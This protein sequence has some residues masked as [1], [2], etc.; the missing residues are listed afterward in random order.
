MQVAEAAQKFPANVNVAVRRRPARPAVQTRPSVDPLQTFP[1]IRDTGMLGKH[2]R[3]R[4][5]PSSS[6]K[7]SAAT[8]PQRTLEDGERHFVQVERCRK[9]QPRRQYV[10]KIYS[11]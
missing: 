11:E 10:L 3:M 7:Y 8:P 2:S 1:T 4:A 6:T 5:H 9:L